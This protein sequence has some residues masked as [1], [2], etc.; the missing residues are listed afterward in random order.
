MDE[1]NGDGRAVFHVVLTAAL[2]RGYP[3]DPLS[4][5]REAASF[6]THRD[7][8][9]AEARL[10]A[11]LDADLQEGAALALRRSFLVRAEI[12]VAM[13]GGG[14]PRRWIADR[15]AVLL[16]RCG[17][18]PGEWWRAEVRG[19][20]PRLAAAD[21]RAS[22]AALG[23]A[24]DGGEAGP[25][26]V[27]ALSMRTAGAA[28]RAAAV[29][30]LDPVLARKL[31]GVARAIGSAAWDGGD[32]SHLAPA[33][34]ALVPLLGRD[35]GPAPAPPAGPAPAARRAGGLAMLFADIPAA[36]WGALEAAGAE[37]GA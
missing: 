22:V 26:G 12:P 35:E 11:E 37:A 5:T 21:M 19:E 14:C 15:A 16:G 36:D 17:A 6:T 33:L 34:D 30:A 4:A 9:E 7:P 20:L 13:L 23:A 28:A 10:F 18:R 8:A 29:G 24:L 1:V 2:E 31:S 27:A 32:A 25:G 3:G